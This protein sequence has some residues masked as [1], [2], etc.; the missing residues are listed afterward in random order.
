MKHIGS[1]TIRD[2]GGELLSKTVV[3]AGCARIETTL[4]PKSATCVTLV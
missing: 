4:S 2:V 3:D 1:K